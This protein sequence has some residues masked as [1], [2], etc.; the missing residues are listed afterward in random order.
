MIKISHQ[1]AK[2]STALLNGYETHGYVEIKI[3]FCVF[4]KL[5]PVLYNGF[6]FKYQM[7]A[8]SQPDLLRHNGFLGNN[9][10]IQ[11]S[12]L[13]L[14][15]TGVEVDAFNMLSV[16]MDLQSFPRVNDHQDN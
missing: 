13:T 7:A 3:G 6:Y 8:N 15:I 12:V 5:Q 4:Q 16:T 14:L 11:G 1:E 2:T 9:M 10:G